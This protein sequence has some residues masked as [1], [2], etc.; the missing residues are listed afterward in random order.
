MSEDPLIEIGGFIGFQGGGDFEHA[1]G[2]VDLDAGQ[3]FTGLVAV[4]AFFGTYV[5]LTYSRRPSS[6]DY[7]STDP[8]FDSRVVDVGIEFYQAAASVRPAIPGL[9]LFRPYAA[10]SMGMSRVDPSPEEL[11]DAWSFAAAAWA[12]GELE[13]S[14]NFAV[15]I[16]GRL[17][18]TVI[19]GG[20]LYC[21]VPEGCQLGLDAKL[22]VQ[23]EIAGGLVVSF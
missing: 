18:I 9:A 19:S 7:F 22:T 16:Y 6:L 15:R 2:T 11:N 14:R 12:G 10:L 3:N 23:A 4:R 8:E 20:S 1:A 5:E 13:L 17:P 21:G